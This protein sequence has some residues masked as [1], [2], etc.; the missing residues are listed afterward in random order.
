M[1]ALVL[2]IQGLRGQSG[3]GTWSSSPRSRGGNTEVRQHSCRRAAHHIG[4]ALYLALVILAEDTALSLIQT[5]SDSCGAEALRR[6]LKRYS[7]STQGWVLSVLH[8][9][10]R[11]KVDFGMDEQA[12]LPRR[13][14]AMGAAGHIIREICTRGVA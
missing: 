14:G 10:R 6:L 8:S 9:I 11:W 12:G 3:R 2:Q 1:G 5:V 4:D 7:P 13:F